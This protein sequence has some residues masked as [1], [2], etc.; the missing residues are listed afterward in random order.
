[1]YRIQEL[2]QAVQKAFLLSE[3]DINQSLNSSICNQEHWKI[4]TLYFAL[5]PLWS[6]CWSMVAPFPVFLIKNIN[7][8]K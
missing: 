4:F 3:C 8:K 2:M 7:P 5:D 1:M 6:C